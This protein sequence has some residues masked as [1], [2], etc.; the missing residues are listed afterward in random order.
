MESKNTYK[1]ELIATARAIARPGF[2]ILAADESTG[3]IGKRFAPIN[4]ENTES[5]RRT[6]R[7]LLFTAPD[8]EKYISGVIMYEET[9]DQSTKDGKNFVELLTEKNILTGIK[10]DT[11][12][13]IIGGT[14]DETATQGLD[15]LGD[16]CANYYAKGA[17]FAKWR[18]VLKIDT[19]TNCPSEV[20]IAENA[21]GLAR[22]A[23]ICQDN[24]LVPIVEPEV[25]CDGTHTIEECAE[26]SE[27]VYAAV[28]KELQDQ[29]VLLE[30][31]LLKPNMITPGKE[32]A[33]KAS[34]AEIAF[35]T[36]RTLSR[37]VPAAIP[38]IHFLS[39]GQSEEEASQNLN[40]MAKLEGVP[41]PWYVSF[42]YGRA[43]QASC[44]KSW[45]GKDEN[46]EA[47]QKTLIE[48]AKGNGDATLGKYEG[49][50][51]SEDLYV[52]KYVY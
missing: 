49:G 33:E 47:A 36:L 38:G 11:G 28:I 41:K 18:A 3:T 14:E 51:S 43:L 1:E 19:K 44:L 42:S 7:E 50:G 23:S 52:K 48:R 8:V 30:G 45:L 5:N 20:A 26:A 15:K 32:C 2:G 10:V 13:V 37:T 9:L 4:V 40:A 22:Y 34:A 21:H 31:C 25:L 12:V 39:G 46:I 17:R 16:R 35:Y 27:R 24:G 6:Y 29:K